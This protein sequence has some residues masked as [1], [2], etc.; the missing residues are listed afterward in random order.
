MVHSIEP[1]V[2]QMQMSPEGA[3]PGSNLQ[4]T[5][6]IA[7]IIDEVWQRVAGDSSTPRA[8]RRPSD[9]PAFHSFR[10]ADPIGL[11]GRHLAAVS[12]CREAASRPDTA[13]RCAALRSFM[14]AQAVVR[15]GT[16]TRSGGRS[17][18]NANAARKTRIRTYRRGGALA[19]RGISEAGAQGKGSKWMI[20]LHREDTTQLNLKATSRS[21]NRHRRKRKRQKEGSDLEEAKKPNVCGHSLVCVDG[22]REVAS[23]SSAAPRLLIQERLFG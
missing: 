11:L 7:Q 16:T 18:G 3:G 21:Q 2:R 20:H 23:N 10:W 8:Q 4:T 19:T 17:E 22:P 9:T 5:S 6:Q 15:E 12:D 14:P 1:A 13:L